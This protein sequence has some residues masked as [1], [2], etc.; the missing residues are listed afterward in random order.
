M[1]SRPA[2]LPA[3]EELQGLYD[4]HRFLDAYGATQSAWSDAQLLFELDVP[5]M[6]LGARLAYR[7]GS[8]RMA[9]RLYLR[10]RDVDPNDPYVRYYGMGYTEPRATLYDFM[11]EF[12]STPFLGSGDADL[13]ASWCASHALLLAD[14]RDFDRAR[15]RLEAARDFGGDAGWLDT[16]DSEIRQ[17]RGDWEGAL[18]AAE[19]VW[20]A[21][22]G[23][24]PAADALAGALS[25][26]GRTAEAAQRI[27]AFALDGGQSYQVLE[28]GLHCA[29]AATDRGETE[30]LRGLPVGLYEASRRLRELAPL[31]DRRLVRR[32]ATV[33]AEAA[34][35]EGLDD[36]FVEH[37]RAS[38]VPFYEAAAR[39]LAGA[40]R[41]E[42]VFL[43]H[44]KVRQQHKTCLPASVVT[45]ASVFD[46][47]LEQSELAER[48]TYDGTP[49]WRVLEWADAHDWIA[50]P[51]L[52]DADGCLA[53]L[54][55]GIP[56]LLIL[57]THSYA[58]AVAAIGYDR[59][60][61]TL[62]FHDPS[63]GRMG[64]V[65]LERLGAGEYPLG[66]ECVALCPRGRAAALEGCALGGED[67]VRTFLGVSR[68]LEVESLAAARTLVETY[69]VRHPDSPQ[70][71]Y[72]DAWVLKESGRAKE[73][74]DRVQP[75]LGA[76][77]GCHL[78]ESLALAAAACS[79]D[80]SYYRGV[81][82][83]IVK[84]GRSPGMEA[85]LEWVYPEP[86][87][88]ARYA[89]LLGQ[90]ATHFDEALA[91]LHGALWR[92][93]YHGE[94][95]H[96]YGDLLWQLRRKDEA[97]L[98]YRIASCLELEND[99][100]A[101]AYAWALKKCGR[102]EEGTGWL[103]SRVERFTGEAGGGSTWM[104]LVETLA[105]FGLPEESLMRLSEGLARRP[106]DPE[107]AS[108]AVSFLSRHGRFADADEALAACR[109]TGSR[110]QFL[111]AGTVLACSRGEFNEAT[112]YVEEWVE[113]SPNSLT[114]RAHCAELLGL[115]EGSG[116]ARARLIEWLEAHPNNDE[117]ERL[118]IDMCREEQD[119]VV[120]VE[121]LDRRLARNPLDA[122]A[123][124]ERALE[125]LHVV[126]KLAAG[127]VSGRLS[128][129]RELVEECTRRSPEE[130][131]T[132]GLRAELAVLEG[133]SKRAIKIFAEALRAEPIY[134]Y[135]I[136]RI[137]ELI[138][139]RPLHE[140]GFVV[141]ILDQIFAS[142]TRDLT[143]ARVAALGLGRL[144]DVDQAL[145]ALERWSRHSPDDPL[146]TEAWADVHLYYGRSKESLDLIV[147]RLEA[148]TRRFPLRGSLAFSLASA[149]KQLY[150]L[151]DAIAE[152]RR[153]LELNPAWT[154]A[155][156]SLVDALERA[157]RRDEGLEE[158]RVAVRFDPGRSSLW[159]ELAGALSGR[160][161]NEE[162]LDVLGEAT[163]KLPSEIE[164]WER[165]IGLLAESGRVAEAID[166]AEALVAA[167]PASAPTSFLLAK[168]L[169]T[170]GAGVSRQRV[171]EA[172]QRAIQLDAR[173]W[174][175][176]WFYALFLSDQTKYVG[177]RRVIEEY[178]DTV[179][180]DTYA[181]GGLAVISW[182]AGNR[183][184]ALDEM[185]ELVTEHPQ[186]EFGWTTLMEWLEE[187]IQRNAGA[188]GYAQELL[189]S[190]VAQGLDIPHL[191]CRR[192]WALE[193]ARAPRNRLA[194]EWVALAERYPTS[195]Q[196][197]VQHFDFLVAGD[198]WDAAAETCERLEGFEPEALRVLARSAV[199]ACHLK[200][201]ERAFD[202]LTTIFQSS[203][204]DVDS[205]RAVWEAVR[206]T[207]TARQA[208]EQALD[209]LRQ[210]VRI[211]RLCLSGVLEHFA[212]QGYRDGYRAL[213]EVLGDGAQE[214]DTTEELSATL[215]S[216][217][218]AGGAAQ[219]IEWADGQPAFCQQ[220]TRVWQRV[221]EAYR[222]LERTE[223]AWEW[224]RSWREREGVEQWVVGNYAALCYNLNRYGEAIEVCEDSLRNCPF[225]GTE[226]M[227]TEVFLR[228]LL[229]VGDW[230]RYER[231]YD[232]YGHTLGWRGG[233]CAERQLLECFAE[234]LAV[235]GN[236]DALRLHR[237]SRR[238]RRE[239]VWARPLWRTV[240]RVRLAGTVCWLFR[241]GLWG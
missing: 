122:W 226:G 18:E 106:N 139:R 94:I 38:K 33:C 240:M 88:Q 5:Q 21:E 140:R 11:Q 228:S 212:A 198:E 41:C 175:A 231:V 54:E 124:R 78:V 192:L 209:L 83:S 84:S 110:A 145:D 61:G 74:M 116:A 51:F 36:A 86:V 150:R 81:L 73:A 178:L 159:I 200:D 188:W 29:L 187:E 166:V 103:V 109:A 164:L 176:V 157:G 80:T 75:T 50:R 60:L 10:G 4:E 207:G 201:H 12:E 34:K 239:S 16:C 118:F 218:V 25:A 146:I 42:R 153:V 171:E 40:S 117:F 37:A 57:R 99:H 69:G 219:V 126:R 158:I 155:R 237:T 101:E 28:R 216:Y 138:E 112:G 169:Q 30:A 183:R 7:L 23:A 15:D 135:G 115:L 64:E 230:A 149:Y 105:S 162:A 6:V 20:S 181:R 170:G 202:L 48:M 39:N 90:S 194:E 111:E 53:L 131:T 79:G 225:D 1:P 47:A 203:S 235:E 52:G 35:A 229:H 66:P 241:L 87:F 214:W 215:E 232:E 179:P 72:L 93:P 220:S 58:H 154:E 14:V 9:W 147:E 71:M 114:A 43:P 96:Y 174:E 95:Y 236:R 136:H 163:T 238:L 82:E 19:R 85:S 120:R 76:G 210:G 172:F 127:A 133:D 65:L 129:F 13:D 156:L 160:G 182:G 205:F 186:Y 199:L 222:K 27:L 167:S 68:A 104:V 161:L 128:R 184:G 45:C 204:H 130:T 119:R 108:F 195:L 208:A 134:D 2:T 234:L 107:L 213:L 56:F 91:R 197:N 217:I 227:L 59:G 24:P 211:S 63:L 168:T 22:P 8:H 55:R 224:W 77:R 189:M 144:L 17:R 180:G 46:V 152:Y 98:A 62:L 92:G 185:Y 143:A 142:Q 233:D 223:E 137:L 151:G 70:G 89:S 206:R 177:A 31:A 196:V 165:R 97:L 100:Y 26:L 221:G 132:C 141:G 67:F 121:V 123:W 3:V 32:F 125:E 148:E 49:M 102:L 44:K 193:A 113:E 190:P 191:A 173:L